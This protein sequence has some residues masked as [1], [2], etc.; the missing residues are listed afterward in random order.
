MI[1]N[2]YLFY[3]FAAL[4]GLFTGTWMSAS[5]PVLLDILGLDLMPKAFGIISLGRGIA[6]L[7]GPPFAG[8]VVDFFG[9]PSHSFLVAGGAMTASS[10]SYF[11][12]LVVY[13]WSRPKD[14]Y[15]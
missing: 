15:T 2:Y 1:S 14:D 5:G 7:G 4:F 9:N 6:A 3:C 11:T 10:L 12:T 8:F 13:W